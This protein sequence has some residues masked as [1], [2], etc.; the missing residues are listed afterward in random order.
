ML[1]M[2]ISENLL[3]LFQMLPLQNIHREIKQIMDVLYCSRDNGLAE[4][5]FHSLDAPG[6]AA[7]CTLLQGMTRFFQVDRAWQLYQETQERGVSVTRDAFNSLI[8]VVCY[9]REGNEHRWHLIQ[10]NGSY[11]YTAVP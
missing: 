6:S 5:V 11:H 8:R 7:Y 9:L 4:K 1:G 10:V 3:L 2:V